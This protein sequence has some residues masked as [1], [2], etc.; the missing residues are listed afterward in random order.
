MVFAVIS[1]FMSRS[2]SVSVPALLLV[3]PVVLPS[4]GFTTLVLLPPVDGVTVP[5]VV[6]VVTFVLFNFTSLI[7]NNSSCCR[8]I[9]IIMFDCGS[10]TIVVCCCLVIN[11]DIFTRCWYFFTINYWVTTICSKF[12]ICC[13]IW[14][15]YIHS[16]WCTTI[17]V[18]RLSCDVLNF[19]S[20]DVNCRRSSGLWFTPAT[21]ITTIFNH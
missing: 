6:P 3:E 13:A 12:N 19:T 11:Y 10:L 8:A 15:R 4:S 5:V 9:T 18:N 2:I 14:V 1:G 21:S 20:L 16:S 17:W 7:I